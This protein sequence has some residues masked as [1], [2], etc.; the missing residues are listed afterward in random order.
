MSIEQELLK[1]TGIK[2]QKKKETEQ[3][4]DQ[5]IY[6]EGKM[7]KYAI[8]TVV[9]VFMLVFALGSQAATV[10]IGNELDHK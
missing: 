6:G 7:G 1:L 4:F 5:N 3:A 10:M 8:Y 2:G 9:L